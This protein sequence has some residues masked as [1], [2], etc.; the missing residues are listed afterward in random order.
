MGARSRPA[1]SGVIPPEA[2][3]AAACPT[4]AGEKP[5]RSICI[6]CIF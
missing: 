6:R 1:K 3:I 4:V 2:G 5:L